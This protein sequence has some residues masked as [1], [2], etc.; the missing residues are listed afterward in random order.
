MDSYAKID[1]SLAEAQLA[2]GESSNLA[3]VCLTY[4]YNFDD[5]KYDD[6]V[7]IL[8]VIAQISIDNCKRK[9]D[10]DLNGEIQRIKKDMDIKRNGYPAFW[11]VI[12]R[13]FNQDN[14]NPDLK[15]PMNYIY[16]IKL[17]KYRNIKS[18]LPMSYF[19]EKFP[20]E[21][22]RRTSR[23]V[24]DIINR[25]S[26]DLYGYNSK[27]EHDD[28]FLLLRSDFDA[29]INDIRKIYVANSYVGLFSWLINR[30]FMINPGTKRNVNTMRS[31]M[32]KN[33]SLLLKF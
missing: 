15:C 12:R 24:E 31:L 25:Y 27:E 29:M 10:I 18:A 32:N 23:K 20:L 11:S 14:I 13:G 9:S 3:Q 28:K 17:P 7:C 4:T 30:G 26:F 2:I 5:Q 8:S 19:Y 6:Y 21:K 1:N 22:T 16:N 33:K